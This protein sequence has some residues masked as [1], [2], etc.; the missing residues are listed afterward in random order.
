MP[1]TKAMGTNAC[2]EAVE[3][4]ARWVD[5][6]SL[7]PRPLPTTATATATAT[8]RGG[9]DDA[10]ARGGAAQRAPQPPQRRPAAVLDP[11]CGR[12]SVLAA[13]NAFTGAPAFGMDISAGCCQVSIDFTDL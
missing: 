5:G 2:R 6:C 12:G 1:Y 7:Q 9:G 8:A 4:C 10:N 13:A 11:F 3:Y